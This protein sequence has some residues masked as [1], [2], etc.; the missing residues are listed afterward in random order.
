MSD[1]ERVDLPR[2]PRPE[3]TWL[4]EIE[5][6]D[7]EGWGVGYMPAA[8]GPQD[9]PK[10]FEFVVRK[11]LPGD[12]V[13]VEVERRSGE[14]IEAR[15]LEW[16]ETSDDR[17]EPRCRHFG[18]RELPREGCGGCTLQSLAYEHQLESKRDDVRRAMDES[19]VAPDRV[20]PTV[21]LDS[22][23]YYRNK[24]EF[25]FGDTADRE[26]ALGLHPR[27]YRYEIVNLDECYL[28]SPFVSA[29]LPR[30]RDWAIEH[31]LQPYLNSTDEGFLRTLTVR[32]GKR[33]GDRLV[34]LTTT[35]DERA[36]FDG[37]TASAG[38]IAEAFD[39]F[40]ER[41]SD[42]LGGD[43]TSVYW[44]QKR[45]VEGKPTRH[46]EHHLSGAEA[47]REQLHLPGGQ[48]LMF[49]VA[50]RAFF[51]PNT[52]G[53]EALYGEVLERAGLESGDAGSVLD[54]YCGTGTIALAMAPYA[55]RVAGI[56]ERTDAVDNARA[57]AERNGLDNAR[58]TAGRVGEVLADP[59]D[60]FDVGSPD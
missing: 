24:M 6:L 59:P 43:V 13:E 48:E 45:T 5:D 57:N 4:I 55:D 41:I 14:R 33:T 21:G 7:A 36:A 18:R 47:I 25:S 9:E 35:H 38:E 2:S 12:V 53:A 28:E 44:T 40:V 1:R 37:G 30:V 10:T 58:F 39:D 42:E 20:E 16:R 32:E 8:V 60:G 15:L 34:E 51:Q 19:G 50:P 27:G 49:E 17:V 23:W 46:V 26:F 11:A 54:L 22:P 52:E 3:T 29:F 56:E 31:G